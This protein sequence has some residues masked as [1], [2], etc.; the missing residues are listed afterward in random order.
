M[1]YLALLLCELTSS[2]AR[3]CNPTSLHRE[4]VQSAGASFS[5]HLCCPSR[6]E[7]CRQYQLGK[8]NNLME[9]PRPPD[10]PSGA[11]IAIS[12]ANKPLSQVN[13]TVS[14]TTKINPTPYHHF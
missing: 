13:P 9:E 10:I 3:W 6:Q 1:S 5:C 12:N 7:A 11:P 8:K 14:E 4:K 2:A